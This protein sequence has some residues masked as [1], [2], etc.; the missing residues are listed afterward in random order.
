[1]LEMKKKKKKKYLES[2]VTKSIATN[3]EIKFLFTAKHRESFRYNSIYNSSGVKVASNPP[4]GLSQLKCHAFP[5][6]SAV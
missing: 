3:R 1:M 6:Y 5:Y 4:F 2:S